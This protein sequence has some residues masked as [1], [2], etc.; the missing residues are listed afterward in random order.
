MGIP[1]Y[2]ECSLSELLDVE[3]NIDREKYPE[4]YQEVLRQIR[5]RREKGE[6]ES[7]PLFPVETDEDGSS[8]YYKYRT[9]WRRFW[10]LF[11]DGLVFIPLSLV[12]VWVMF[13]GITGLP[14]FLWLLVSSGAYIFYSISM[15]AAFGQTIGK[16]VTR[17]VV[18]DVRESKLR[19]R[20][21]VMRDIVPLLTWPLSIHWAYLEAFGGLSQAELASLWTNQAASYTMGIWTLLELATMLLNRKRRAFHGF[22]AG[23]VVVKKMHEP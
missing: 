7:D 17:V 6:S 19:L 3:R 22:I 4:R 13:S 10:A 5:L 18:L 15:H 11:I 23:A 2:E 12:Q 1:D 21:A 9:F 20:Q 8:P 14:L 16:M